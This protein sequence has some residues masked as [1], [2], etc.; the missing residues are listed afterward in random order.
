MLSA[1]P[2]T[3]ST[4]TQVSME[5][6]INASIPSD[7]HWEILH[8]WASRTGRPVSNLAAHLILSAIDQAVMDGRVP[9]PIINDIHAS[10]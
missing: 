6:R 4:T 3:T 9:A 7:Y 1:K 8:Q 10:L 2:L 5:K